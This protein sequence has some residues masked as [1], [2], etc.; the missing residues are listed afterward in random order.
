VRTR[1]AA[2]AASFVF[3][4]LA[5][6]VVAGMVPW[7]LTGW[8]AERALLGFEVGRL[9]GGLAVIIGVAILVD[10]FSRFALEGRGTPAPVAPTV[11]LV[12]SGLY[13]YVRNPMYVGVLA[14]IVGQSFLL[15]RVVLLVYAAL[16]W[17]AF[18]TFVVVYEEPTL[19][20]QFGRSY[21]AYRTHVPRWLPRLDP[22]R[23]HGSE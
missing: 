3:F 4:W 7:L 19:A 1:A 13:R 21:D 22:W 14:V 9:A 15:G 5:P 23:E 17:L 8:R 16:V 10:C 18:H 11:R 12:A 6:G 20:R 2:L